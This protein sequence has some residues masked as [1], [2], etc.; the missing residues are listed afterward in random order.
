[1]G[2]RRFQIVIAR[3]EATA[4]LS[5]V[6]AIPPGIFPGLAPIVILPIAASG[7]AAGSRD[8]IP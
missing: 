4:R 5:S 8:D 2:R 1:M 7:E 6:G 3:S